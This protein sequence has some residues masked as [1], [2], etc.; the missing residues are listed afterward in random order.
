MFFLLIRELVVAQI[1]APGGY[2]LHKDIVYTTAGNWQGRMDIYSPATTPKKA[3]PLIIYI[4][5][6]GWV[7]GSK[8]EEK[9]FSIFFKKEYVIANVEYRIAN[10]APAPAAI[11]D[12]R[13]AL[14]YL[15]QNNAKWHI[16]KERI[17]IAGSSAG[18]HLALIAG[19]L[20]NNNVFD[21][22]CT[23]VPLHIAGIIDKYGPTDLAQWDAMKN[24]GKASSS[25]LGGRGNDSVFVR[26]LSPV[27][28]VNYNSPPVLIIHGDADHTVPYQQ[29]LL[30]LDKL[31]AFGVKVEMY[32]AKGG[33][34]GNFNETQNNEIEKLANGFVTTCTR[35]Y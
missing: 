21:N 8:E 27:Y 11:Q 18:G 30:L 24:P 10:Q 33:R 22:N 9:W 19:L 34:H 12:I 32:T 14:M 16:D 1:P 20:Q 15:A 25:W 28:Y 23:P 13:C 17:V 29:S 2:E 5:G 31:K 26:S 4:H 6:G 35:I 7:H 3:L